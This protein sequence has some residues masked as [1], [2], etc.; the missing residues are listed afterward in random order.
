MKNKKLLK[1][2]RSNDLAKKW[3]KDPD[4]YLRK[5][6]IQMANNI[7]R[8]LTSYAIKILKTETIMR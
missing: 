2:K 6:D 5:Q 7:E 1:L 4:R 8:C 3:T